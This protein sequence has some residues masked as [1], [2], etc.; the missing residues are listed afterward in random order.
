MG[1]PV[2]ISS[3]VIGSVAD[4]VARHREVTIAV[5]HLDLFDLGVLR[6][7]PT[8]RNRF[9]RDHHGMKPVTTGTAI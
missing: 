1:R 2:D 3:G 5:I 8:V 6:L 9:T 4:R 7:E